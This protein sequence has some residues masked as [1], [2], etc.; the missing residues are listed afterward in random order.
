[1]RILSLFTLCLVLLSAAEVTEEQFVKHDLNADGKVTQQELKLPRIFKL[2]DRNKDGVITR[3]ELGLTEPDAPPLTMAPTVIPANQAALLGRRMDLGSLKDINGKSVVISENAKAVIVALR[4]PDCPVAAKVAP[5][6]A[7]VTQQMAA[8][9][10]FVIYLHIGDERNCGLQDKKKHNFVGHYIHDKNARL[11][12]TFQAKTT[13]EVFVLDKTMTLRY[14]GA[15]DDQYGIGF[16]KD[17]AQFNFLRDAVEAVIDNREPAIVATAAPGCSLDLRPNKKQG[18]ITWHNRISRI[19]QRN[20]V[21]CHHQGGAGPFALETYKQVSGRRKGMISDIVDMDLMPPWFADPKHQTWSND[22]RL[23]ADD[24]KDLL[25]WIDAG[26]PE[27]NPND[28]I[29][30]QTPAKNWKIGKPDLILQLP[31]KVTVQAEGTIPYVNLAVRNPLKEDRWIEAYQIK[32]TA[33]EVVHHV[34]VFASVDGQRQGGIQGFFAGMVPGQDALTYAPGFAKK[35]PAG[36]ILRFQMHYTTNGTEMIDQTQI[37]FRFAK[38]PPKHVM[39]TRSAANVRFQIPPHAEAHKVI[40]QRRIRRETI[41]TAF[42]PHMH[43][44]GS[45]YTYELIKPD[46]S[47]ETILHIPDYDFNWQLRYQLAEP[48]RVMPGSILRTTGVFNNSA[49]NPANPDPTAIVRH[50]EQTWDEMQIGYWE[51]Y[52]R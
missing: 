48:I 27:G 7:R 29:T 45:G 36:A 34:L 14:R 13:T 33:P 41:F 25:A 52:E 49:S 20:C 30:M 39:V 22:R 12:Q 16:T 28:G 31:R 2:L 35:L 40:A 42:M 4:D 19:M 17:K 50:G 32:P 37:G 11:C 43:V 15:I 3:T 1:M 38:E 6:L 26:C 46:K 47:V 8:K 23:N 5:A 24:K 21:E 18:A 9:G 51:G 44:R 10:A